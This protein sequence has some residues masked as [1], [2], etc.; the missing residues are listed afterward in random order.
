MTKEQFIHCMT[1][2]A[3]PSE[4]FPNRIQGQFYNGKWAVIN[5]TGCA[6]TCKDT[7]AEA[8]Q[9]ARIWTLQLINFIE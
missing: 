3:V 4:Q 1:K 8:E 7:K 9:A 5:E 6:I 2:E